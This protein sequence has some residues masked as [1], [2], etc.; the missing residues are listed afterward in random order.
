MGKA[1]FA[2]GFEVRLHD[3]DAAGVLFYAHLFRHTHDAYESLMAA[4]G[5]PLQDLIRAGTGLPIIH[6]E[7]D[8]QAPM[9]QGERIRVELLV[10]EIRPRSFRL[11]Y[12]FL[13]DKGVTRARAHTVHV[14]AG[15]IGARVLPQTLRQS[16][17][18]WQGRQDQGSDGRSPI[19]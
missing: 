7:A 1:P 14:L 12:R 2:Y 11:D 19:P 5:H 8:Y 4:A 3:T 13:D 10:A 16:L 18:R 17:T 6:A 9:R 15:A